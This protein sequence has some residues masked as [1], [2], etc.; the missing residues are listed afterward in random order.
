MA[1]KTNTK[2]KKAS[3]KPPAKEVARRSRQLTPRGLAAGRAEVGT[4]L[5]MGLPGP[6][7]DAES[8]ALLRESQPGGI[9]LFKRNI[10]G[11]A[12]AFDLLQ[13]CSSFL[14]GPL[15]Q[16]VDLEG[17]T[18]DRLRD[19]FGREPSAASV[20]ATRDAGLY[21][22]HGEVVGRSTAAVGFNV[23]FAPVL[24]LARPASLSV[25]GSRAVSPD[26]KQVV[27]YAR[28]FLRGMRANGVMGC[29]KHFPGLGE[30]SF[31]T[32]HVL[33]TIDKPWARLWE[34][35]ILPYRL[36]RAQLPTIML[37]HASYS[38]VT[39]KVEPV[40]ISAKWLRTILREKMGYRGLAITDDL[41]MGAVQEAVG[42]SASDAAI[43]TITAGGD[44]Y[45]VCQ[46]PEHA[47]Q[48][49]AEVLRKYE[50]SAVFAEHVKRAASRVR[51]VRTRLVA[52]HANT[53]RPTDATVRRLTNLVTSLREAVER[54]VP[55]MEAKSAPAG[56]V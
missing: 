26:P 37:A 25:L 9:I 11:A 17:G 33:P 21:R 36:L 28:E 50:R 44:I 8:Q 23:D 49:Q 55:A 4:L 32:H 30:V 51:R 31:D 29:G 14:N 54:A 24:D 13:A 52:A 7:L 40:S 12:Q 10:T 39:K 20:F 41:D 18:V 1:V 45:L 6:E 46:H 56:E 38:A 22:R 42:G 43:R 19:V 15:L 27:A 34:E 47:P 5:V 16:C 2:G 35:D 48:I 3:A 53:R